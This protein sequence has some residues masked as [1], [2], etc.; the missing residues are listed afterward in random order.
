MKKYKRTYALKEMSKAKII[1]KKSER[2]IRYE[3]QL[4]SQ[5]NHPFIVNMYY[6][7]QDS[8]NLYLIM[9]LLTGGDLRYHISRY[10]KFNEEQ[11]KFFVAC[12]LLGLD[13]IHTNNIIHRD[14]KP[15]NLVLEERGY[16]RIT[17]F[18]IAKIYQKENSSE[19][20]GTPG[21]MAPEVM[22]AQNHTIAVDYF[23][24]GVFT[25][26][27]MFGIRP[28]TGKSR[29]EIKDKI[30]AKQVQIKRNEI[31]EGWSTEAADFINRL[32]QRKPVNR[33]G[34]RGAQEVREHA[35]LKYYPWKDLYEKKIDPPFVPRIGDNFDAKYCN[36]PEKLGNNT[37]EKYDQYLRDE[38]FK[39]AFKDFYFYYNDFDPN[40]KNNSK[41]KKL[42]NPHLNIQSN[43]SRSSTNSNVREYIGNGNGKI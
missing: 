27:F 32:L 22:C 33:L 6:S 39:D 25:Y 29:K 15:E 30:M 21:Y 3:K 5:M 38:T 31:P 37:R 1:D 11:T 18:G 12:I 43:Y 40:D 14:I 10:K 36:A 42:F 28:Y 24:L 26:E 4:L 41:E 13:Y 23:A 20:S 9:D 16:V 2:S 35:W 19:T 17:D 34:L 7:F 8:E